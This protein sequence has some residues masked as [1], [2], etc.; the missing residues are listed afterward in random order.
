MKMTP[1]YIVPVTFHIL[2]SILVFFFKSQF[3]SW[4]LK[5]LGF[6]LLNTSSNSL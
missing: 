2:Q 3:I 1:R 6:N 4:H 5:I